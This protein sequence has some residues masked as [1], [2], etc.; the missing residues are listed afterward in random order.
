[1]SQEPRP[2]ELPPH[3]ARQIAESFGIDAER[4]DR[5]RPG[6]PDALMEQIVATSP[7]L[8]VVDVGTGTGI[9]ARQFQAA[10]CTVLGVEPDA[11]MTKFARRVG[12]DVEVA[13]FEGW[14]PGGRK[15]DVVVSG[16]AWH[17]VDPV[18]GPVK[19]AQVLRPGGRLAAFGH[20]FQLPPDLAE[21]SASSY[22]Q[23]LPE[24]LPVAQATTR[25]LETYQRMYAKGNGRTDF[26]AAYLNIKGQTFR[27]SRS[28]LVNRSALRVARWA[29]CAGLGPCGL[30]PLEGLPRGGVHGEP[31]EIHAN[32]T[33]R[34][35]ATV[36]GFLS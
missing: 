24:S 4:Y 5:S 13:S 29:L 26:K 8:D 1:M 34:G 27:R 7:G 17:W 36:D 32:P 19:A 23:L 15:F 21:V 16:T 31:R 11:R 35:Y 33:G 18:A 25:A 2:S 12:L 14:D 20:A 22:Q 28:P 10:G 6:Y 3:R 9:V 30:P